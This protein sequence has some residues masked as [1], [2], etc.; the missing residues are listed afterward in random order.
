MQNPLVRVP[1]A[2]PVLERANA[3]RRR[4]EARLRSFDVMDWP[5]VRYGDAPEQVIRM[6]EL[7]DLAPRD[8]W[9]AVLLIHGGGWVEG[10][11]S[12]FESLAPRFARRGIAAA[13][14]NYRLGPVA[15]WPAQLKDAHAALDRLLATQVDPERIAVWGHSAGGQLALMLALQ[16]PEDV[17]CVVA[18][19]APTDLELLARHGTERLDLVF[20]DDQLAAASPLHLRPP[21]PPPMLLIHGEADPVV[22]VGHARAMHARWPQA[23]ELWEL[24]DGDHGLRWPPVGALRLR[25]AAIAWVERQLA[26]APRGSKWKRRKK[27]DR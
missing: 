9:P 6:W 14:M 10:D 1:A 21:A 19:G 3:L 20:D 4:V 27:A 22:P 13:A 15:R 17:R 2:L 25:R 23:S 7:N 24:P 8:G 18:L 26:P 16:R 5:G 12:A 11:L